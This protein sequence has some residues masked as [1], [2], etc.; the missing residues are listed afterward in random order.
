MTTKLTENKLRNVV[1][2]MINEES[3][4]GRE[5]GELQKNIEIIQEILRL[6]LELERVTDKVGFQSGV[7]VQSLQDI[8]PEE[9]REYKKE[10]RYRKED[11]RKITNQ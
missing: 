10:L 4:G 1:R 8:L 3:A 5:L 9:I 7:Y 11:L 6:L 2:K